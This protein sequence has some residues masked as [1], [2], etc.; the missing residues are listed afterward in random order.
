MT[1]E[2]IDFGWGA[3][4]DELQDSYV[5]IGITK[6]DGGESVEGSLTLAK[7]ASNL[8]Y[9]AVVP[10]SSEYKERA[11]K[12]GV[13]FGKQTHISIPSR[14]F[15]RQTFDEQLPSIDKFLTRLEDKI[16][17]GDIDRR[18]ALEVVGDF[19]KSEIQRNMRLKGKFA[20]NSPRTIKIKGSDNELI[21]TG[22]LVGSMDIDTGD[23]I[24]RD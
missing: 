15:M 19:H 21:D 14:P 11:A 7:L 1:Q 10:I 6:K 5:D 18:L 16:A 17:G 22:R 23:G 13:G 9:G 4:V 20:P 24:P 8:E 12:K 2:I 3:Y